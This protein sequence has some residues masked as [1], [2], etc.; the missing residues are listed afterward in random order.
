M[1]EEGRFRADLFFR[2]NVFPIELPPLRER[3]SD[4]PLLARHLV[5]E[6]ARR[7]QLP[8]PR[9][10]EGAG[11]LLAGQSWPGNV[12]ELANLLERAVILADGPELRPAD[13][14][15]LLGAPAVP[16]RLA[17]GERDRLRQAL[18]EMD[19]DKRR[20]ADLLG[21]SYRALLRKVKE[22]DLLGVPK[23]RS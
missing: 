7:H 3:A 21:M 20:A 18:I 14:E 22:L 4:L 16:A 11:E 6:I 5:A 12:R 9:L 19:G 13:L 15:P 10:G 8:A 23:Y 17:H 1:V 2:L